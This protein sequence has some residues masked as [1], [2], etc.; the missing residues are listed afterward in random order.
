[1][2]E[3]VEPERVEVDLKRVHVERGRQFGGVWLGYELLQRLQPIPFSDRA[4]GPSVGKRFLGPR[5]RLYW[6]W[7]RWCQP[8]S[9]LHLAEQGYE[10]MALADLLGVPA[11]KVNHYRLYRALDQLLPHKEALEKHLKQRLEELFQIEYDALRRDEH[12]L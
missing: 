1:L 5:W 2:F 10:S 8:S 6:S 9:E 7:A 4:T 3:T 11:E 12:L